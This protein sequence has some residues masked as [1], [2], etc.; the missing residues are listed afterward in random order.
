MLK[1]LNKKLRNKGGF[2]LT[3]LIVVVAILGILV[4]VAVPTV[5]G[6]IDDAKE[7]A[8][9]SNAKTL[10]NAIARLMAKGT[11]QRD[12]GEISTDDATIISE[13][14]KEINPIPECQRDGY[15]FVLDKATAKVTAEKDFTE[16]EGY[17][18]LEN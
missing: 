6:Y 1:L 15:S 4:A 5:I 18:I 13:I 2:T 3:E 7:S 9:L 16:T 17:L 14:L 8:D 12:S 11:I 10:E